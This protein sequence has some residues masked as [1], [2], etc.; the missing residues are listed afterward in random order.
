M[1]KLKNLIKEI[2]WKT[3]PGTP[4]EVI[5]VLYKIVGEIEGEKLNP[6]DY[7]GI[8]KTKKGEETLWVIQNRKQ[9]KYFLVFSTFTKDWY[10]SLI[11]FKNKVPLS[12]QVLNAVIG[13]WT[14]S[15][16]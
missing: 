6:M 15:F 8:N 13:L 1:I 16:K 2:A 5:D 12:D 10:Y 9:P 11:G 4:D 7:I 14:T 3:P